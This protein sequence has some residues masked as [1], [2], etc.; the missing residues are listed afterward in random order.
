MIGCL[1]QRR[2]CSF[3]RCGVIEKENVSANTETN[4]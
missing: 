4:I 2:K 3:S 1:R